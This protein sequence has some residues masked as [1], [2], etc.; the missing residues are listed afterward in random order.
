[1]TK[2]V[3]KQDGEL[4]N[5]CE[6]EFGWKRTTTYTMLHKRKQRFHIV[7]DYVVVPDSRTKKYNLQTVMFIA[8]K[9]YI[10]NNY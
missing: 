5:L 2:G 4:T 1:M 6:N 8:I 3:L 9:K 7:S 10:I